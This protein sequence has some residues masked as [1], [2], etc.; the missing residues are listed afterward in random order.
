MIETMRSAKIQIVCRHFAFAT[1]KP[2][3]CKVVDYSRDSL[4]NILWCCVC[5]SESFLDLRFF[6]QVSYEGDITHL[7]LFHLSVCIR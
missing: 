2:H 3:A 5:A 1:S 7:R 4:V 6:E